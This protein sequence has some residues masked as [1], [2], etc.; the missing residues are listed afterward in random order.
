MI[1]GAVEQLTDED[2]EHILAYLEDMRVSY[3]GGL[4]N[5][6]ADI[7]MHRVIMSRADNT[8]IAALAR[9]GLFPFGQSES[10]SA[11]HRLAMHIRT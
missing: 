2:C 11:P 4:S 3:A 6:D 9:R 7:G 1:R 8:I 10:G 5:T